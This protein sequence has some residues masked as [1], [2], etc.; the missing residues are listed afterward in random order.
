MRPERTHGSISRG[1]LPPNVSVVIPTLNEAKNLPHVLP[2]I[3]DWVYEVII[4]DGLSV[5]GSVEVAQRSHPGVRALMVSE[6]GKGAALRAGFEAAKGDIIVTLDADGSTDPAEIPAFVGSLIAG[7]DVAMGSRFAVGGGTSDMELHRRAGNW[8]LT[9]LV[10]VAFGARYSDLCYGYVAFWK[11]VLPHLDGTFS[12]FEVETVMHIRAVRAGLRIAEVPSFE[13]ERIFGSSNLRTIRDGARVFH[14]ICRE[15]RQSRTVEAA[16][17]VDIDLVRLE[18]A[19]AAR[20]DAPPW[21]DLTDDTEIVA[22][23][24]AE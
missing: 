11:D 14:A 3:P 1:A 7:A 21:L 9:K 6:P 2:R 23:Q 15:W 20:A 10:K 4:V 24:V 19:E 18:W 12:G 5:D 22:D 16:A 13:A 8:A 17:P